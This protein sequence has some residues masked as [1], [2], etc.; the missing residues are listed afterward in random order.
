[1]CLTHQHRFN[2]VLLFLLNIP[3][4]PVSFA[5]HQILEV[6]FQATILVQPPRFAVGYVSLRNN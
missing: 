5:I 1:M 2:L 3:S 4:R 6:A